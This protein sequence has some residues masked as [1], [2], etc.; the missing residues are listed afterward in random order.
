MISCSPRLADVLRSSGRRLTPPHWNSRCVNHL[1]QNRPRVAYRR[2]CQRRVGTFVARI[3]TAPD[4]R[5]LGPA[6][7]PRYAR[8]MSGR[9]RLSSDPNE[10]TL[11]FSIRAHRPTR[12][13]QPVGTPR[14]L[15]NC[16]S[17]ASMRRPASAAWTW[18]AG[19]SCRTGQ[20][21]SKS[22][23][24]TSTRKPRGSTT[25]CAAAMPTEMAALARHRCHRLFGRG[26]RCRSRRAI[27]RS[28]LQNPGPGV[29]PGSRG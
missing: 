27:R 1:T 10:T 16:R 12:T 26:R 3:A 15:T 14:P 4:G 11:V 29:Y 20:R 13:S 28:E 22:G 5:P 6:P 24:Q 2:R 17:F 21:T 19:A 9:V 18:C 25:G 7:P 23:S 8:A